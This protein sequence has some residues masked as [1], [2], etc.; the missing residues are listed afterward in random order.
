MKPRSGIKIISLLFAVVFV[1]SMIGYMAGARASRKKSANTDTHTAAAFPLMQSRNNLFT[2]DKLS[3]GSQTGNITQYY[4]LRDD[5]GTLSLFCKYEDGREELYQSYDVSVDSL[6]ESD[7][8]LLKK[9]IKADA[10]SDALQ[11]AEDYSS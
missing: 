3:G 1:S 2:G 8:I 6:P 7:R 10:L 4:V 5:G 9:G 11:L